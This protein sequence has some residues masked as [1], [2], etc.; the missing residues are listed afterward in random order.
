LPLVIDPQIV[1][2]TY[3]GGSGTN[4][5]RV[6]GFFDVFFGSQNASPPFAVSDLATDIALDPAGAIYVAGVAYST[7]FPTKGAFQGSDNTTT[8]TSNAFVAKFDPTRAGA[9][10]L[11]YST[12]LG[13]RGDPTSAGANGDQANGIAVDGSGEAYVTGFTYSPNFPHTPGAFETVNNQ[14]APN[15]N[16]GF[17]AELNPAGNGLVYSTF[18]NGS[19]GAAASRIALLPGCASNCSAYVVGR[20]A[21]AGGTDFPTMNGYRSS[22]PDT[23]GNSA[24]YLLVLNG[25]GGSLQ[26]STFFG[27]SGGTNGGEAATDA[28][29]D[30]AGNAYVTGSTFSTDLPTLHPFQPTLNGTGFSSIAFVGEV[31][32]AKSGAGSLLYSTYLGGTGTTQGGDIGTGVALD[33][34][35]HIFVDGSTFSNDFPLSANPYQSSNKASSSGGANAFISELDISQTGHSQ[36]AYSTYLGGSGSRLLFYALGD[37]ATS[38]AVDGAGH[39]F[40]AGGT[41]SPDFPTTSSACQP[42]RTNPGFSANAFVSELDPQS[43]TKSNQLVFS[44]YLG[45]TGFDIAGGL[46]L[47]A[48][49]HVYAAGMAGSTN[50]PVTAGAFQAV[51]RA[52]GVSSN[53]F[54]SVLD[55][56]STAC[57]PPTPTPTLIPTSS[58]TPTPTATP[59][60]TMIATATTAG[61]IT[62]TPTLTPAVTPTASASA[63]TATA[64]PEPFGGTLSVSPQTIKF[65]PIDRDIQSTATANL[66]ISNSG[67]GTLTGTVDASGLA[68]PFSVIAGGAQF[69]LTNGQSVTVTIRFA[70]VADGAYSSMLV[71]TSSDAL[72][73]FLDVPISG[74]AYSLLPTMT[75]TPT[76]TSTPGPAPSPGGRLSITPGM[77]DFGSVG[78]GTEATR[79][80]KIGNSG[81]T[82]LYGS[83]DTSA[84]TAVFSASGDGSFS[85]GP[86]QSKLVTIHF[87]PTSGHSFAA[88]IDVRSG[89]SRH[90]S[91]S[92]PVKG[93]GVPGRLIVAPA[94]LRFG[95]VAKGT[96]KTLTLVIRNGQLGVLNGSVAITAADG[97]FSLVA[98]GGGFTLA[99]GKTHKVKVKF[100]PSSKGP[101]EGVFAISSDDPMVQDPFPVELSGTGE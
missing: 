45:G 1:Y 29:V 94:A 77:V 19:A 7:D 41:F 37:A 55:P 17:V 64:T 40:V 59:T 91:K 44:T 99:R 63:A 28:A 74:M 49:G 88:A 71:I 75:P 83:V 30:P 10:S 14:G 78:V 86:N 92:L 65:P 12:Y 90:P 69:G 24:A 47:D 46:K 56:S 76:P 21:T 80:V 43:S 15:V 57:L 82:R 58:P 87:Q 95:A 11:V 5:G 8:T 51:N 33:A 68:P 27:G 6:P 31:N 18:V 79:N 20:T 48:S 53:A 54:V 4:Q 70:P 34:S 38:V 26:Y 32:P 100:V 52:A 93:I 85:L 9:A 66:T 89:D 61:S 72:N 22:N 67:T 42:M 3:L 16:N 101:F 60:P 25:G 97:P 2:S 50:F 84:L 35:G 98:G 96:S 23:H 13:G 81:R 73:P 62:P 39:V 36:L